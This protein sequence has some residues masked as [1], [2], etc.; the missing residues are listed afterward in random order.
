M[1]KNFLT[2]KVLFLVLLFMFALN[3]THAQVQRVSNNSQIGITAGALVYNGRYSV[4]ASTS[5]F[6][7]WGATVFYV[8]NISL[9]K[10][11]NLKAAL[12]GGQLKGDNTAVQT[13]GG[14]GTF[15]ANIVEFSIRAEY[16][17][18]NMN[19]NRFSPYIATGPGFYSL[20]NYNS[21]MGNKAS[22]DLMGFVL[23]VGGGIKYSV[24]PRTQLLFDGTV[25]LFNKNLDNY[26]A[27]NNVNKYFTLGLGFSY[28]LQK[29]NTL[30]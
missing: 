4:D 28:K 14:Q 17:F 24:G 9:I 5:T 27:T 7:S 13:T 2:A 15:S 11:L 1:K 12:M 19:T 23:P 18:L 16:D 26:P 8:P 21:S 29:P 6:A 3:A 30:W 10:N 25:R 20:L 22:S